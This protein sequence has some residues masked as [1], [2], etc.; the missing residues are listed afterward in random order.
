METCPEE[1]NVLETQAA[2][3]DPAAGNSCKP[4]HEKVRAPVGL[5]SWNLL[6]MITNLEQGKK[7]HI[8][9]AYRGT[10]A[11]TLRA[12]LTQILQPFLHD[13]AEPDYFRLCLELPSIATWLE[14]TAD[15]PHELLDLFLD[16]MANNKKSSIELFPDYLRMMAD[17]WET[18]IKDRKLDNNAS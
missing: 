2:V 6:L 11:G 7:K 18:I 12:S 17:I 3:A 9:I 14:G 8:S 13:H 5:S 4:A 10:D 16:N 1:E 15:L